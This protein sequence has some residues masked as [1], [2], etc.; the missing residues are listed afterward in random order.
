[1]SKQPTLNPLP[2]GKASVPVPGTPVSITAGA[3][4]LGYTAKDLACQSIFFQALPANTGNV[5]IGASDMNTT[6]M[7]GVLFI[8]V[9][10]QQQPYTSPAGNSID[11]TRLYVDA[12]VADEGIISG[13]YIY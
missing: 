2:Y 7:A 1:M 3:I 6:T 12:D 13:G 9:A 4:A 8:L 5:Y 10:G 11:P